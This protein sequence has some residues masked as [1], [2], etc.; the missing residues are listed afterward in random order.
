MVD[1]T[2]QEVGTPELWKVWIEWHC[3]RK[4]EEDFVG[5]IALV[6]CKDELKDGRGWQETGMD[7]ETWPSESSPTL[8]LPPQLC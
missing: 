5:L 6:S 3:G 4:G 2:S 1:V 7:K 8:T